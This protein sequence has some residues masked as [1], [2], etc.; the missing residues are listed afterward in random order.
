MDLSVY[1]EEPGPYGISFAGSLCAFMVARIRGYRDN[2]KDDF[3]HVPLY[4]SPGQHRRIYHS[5]IENLAHLLE[6]ARGLHLQGDSVH[7]LGAAAAHPADL[8][9][10]LL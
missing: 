8:V 6:R 4:R 7:A 3:R 1:R 10:F 9:V 2:R 5:I